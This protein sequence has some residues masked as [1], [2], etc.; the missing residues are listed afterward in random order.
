VCGAKNS[1]ATDDTS[2]IKAYAKLIFRTL[3]DE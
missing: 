3:T 2:R 1:S